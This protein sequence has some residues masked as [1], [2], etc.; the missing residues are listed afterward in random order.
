MK[1]VFISFLFLQF[2]Y[3]CNN[4]DTQTPGQPENDLDAAATF[5]RDA[6]D[7][8]W[9]LAKQYLLQDSVN[10]QLLE[11]AENKYK[12]LRKEEQRNYRDAVPRFYD[13][14][15]IGDSI[16]IVNYSN[17]YMNKKD[18]LKIVRINGQ[19][20]IDLKYSLLP[21]SSNDQ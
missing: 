5:I 2:F 9:N 14:R 8:K 10:V 19:W 20:L 3:A 15:K 7:G 1:K 13:S 11:T 6:L 18:S 12:S 16:T 21:K 4:K 17:S